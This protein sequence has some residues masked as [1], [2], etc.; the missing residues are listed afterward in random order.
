MDRGP[1]PGEFDGVFQVG[2]FG[3]EDGGDGGNAPLA[4][5]SADIFPHVVGIWP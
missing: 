4:E 3:A 1:G 5:L 2:A